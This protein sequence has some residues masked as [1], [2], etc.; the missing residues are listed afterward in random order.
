MFSMPLS[1]PGDLTLTKL[2]PGCVSLTL[3][4]LLT[5]HILLALTHTLTRC[6][7]ICLRGAAVLAPWVRPERLRGD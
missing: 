2:L 5:G 7:F 6:V 4:L 1:D 3:A